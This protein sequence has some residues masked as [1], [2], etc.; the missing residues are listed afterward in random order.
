MNH[1]IYKLDIPECSNYTFEIGKYGVIKIEEDIIQT[2]VG[3]GYSTSK[4]IYRIVFDNGNNIEISANVSGIVL[5]K[6]NIPENKQ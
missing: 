4:L 1:L 6:Q 5:F 3:D 2:G